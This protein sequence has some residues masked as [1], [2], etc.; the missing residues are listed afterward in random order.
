MTKAQKTMLENY[1]RSNVRYLYQI[2]GRF[3]TAKEN[4]YKHCEYMREKLKGYDVRIP[5]HNQNTFTYAFRYVKDGAVWLH[6]ETYR[7][8][9]DFKIREVE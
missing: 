2:Y 1:E 8:T 4:A 3:S 5:T 7:H 6:Y 9:H